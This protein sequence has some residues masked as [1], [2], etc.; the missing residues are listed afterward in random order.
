MP[1]EEN[2]TNKK[3][4]TKKDSH[5]R[6]T[7]NCTPSAIECFASTIMSPVEVREYTHGGQVNDVNDDDDSKMRKK[8]I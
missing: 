7:Q 8:S 4:K 2:K 3:K 1:L 6:L 5:P